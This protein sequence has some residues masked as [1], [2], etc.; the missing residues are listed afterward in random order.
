[1]DL[2]AGL[3][4]LQ[5]AVGDGLNRNIPIKTSLL[6]VVQVDASGQ[7]ESVYLAKTAQ[8]AQPTKR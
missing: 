2:S 8:I 5:L 6:G 4:D 7:F 3:Y 1:M